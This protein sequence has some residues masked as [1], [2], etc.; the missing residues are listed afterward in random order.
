[1]FLR[2]GLNLYSISILLSL[3]PYWMPRIHEVIQIQPQTDFNLKRNEEKKQWIKVIRFASAWGLSFTQVEYCVRSPRHKCT[4]DP[5]CILYC[6]YPALNPTCL[7]VKWDQLRLPP[8]NRSQQLNQHQT[9]WLRTK[10]DERWSAPHNCSQPHW[11]LFLFL[12]LHS[13]QINRYR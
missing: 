5:L 1:M 3:K 13:K 8:V 7:S 4:Y 2:T 9:H 6:T 10:L 12:A 11:F